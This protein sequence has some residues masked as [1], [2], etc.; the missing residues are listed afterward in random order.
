MNITKSNKGVFGIVFLLV[1]AL[2]TYAFAYRGDGPMGAGNGYGPADCPYGYGMGNVQLTEQE[3]TQLDEARDKFF[4]QTKDLK[5]QIYA[6]HTTL[7][8]ELAKET[9][10]TK[11][12]SKLQSEISDLKK[13]LDQKRL[14]HRLEVKKINPQLG[15]GYGY[16]RG[17]GGRGMGGGMRPCDRW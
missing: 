15:A 8:E 3:R 5:D 17:Q 16:G 9:P 12:A 4:E 13:Q 10:D 14:E 7:N 2:S 1:L 11:K 6:K